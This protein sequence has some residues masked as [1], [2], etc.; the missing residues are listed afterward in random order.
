MRE[1]GGGGGTAGLGRTERW[2]PCDALQTNAYPRLFQTLTTRSVSTGH[3]ALT[4]NLGP[5]L[6][7]PIPRTGVGSPISKTAFDTSPDLPAQ[8][9]IQSP[10]GLCRDVFEAS[11]AR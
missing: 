3:A 11:C 2:G 9:N 5:E 8:R 6:D 7:R 4:L 10:P 1:W